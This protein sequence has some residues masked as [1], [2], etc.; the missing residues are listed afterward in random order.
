VP[1]E[2]E[3]ESVVSIGLTEHLSLTETSEIQKQ[4]D[5][6]T[7]SQMEDIE[8]RKQSLTEREL[9]ERFHR[10]IVQMEENLNN[11]LGGEK[12]ELGSQFHRDLT[13]A[14]RNGTPWPD[15]IKN[16]GNVKPQPKQT[17]RQAKKGDRK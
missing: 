16:L 5:T 12:V 6:E 9:A 15:V 11:S 4:I 17:K 14:Q 10:E 1:N 7:S 13:E 3:G 2:D 8:R